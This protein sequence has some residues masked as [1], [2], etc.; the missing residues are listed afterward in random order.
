MGLNDNNI[1]AHF[2]NLFTHVANM[3][4]YQKMYFK[5]RTQESLI[6]AKEYETK[7][8]KIIEAWKQDRDIKQLN[9][10]LPNR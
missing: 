7:V 5:T 4:Y 2:T 8:D 6:T 3:R 10:E 9:L 1:Q